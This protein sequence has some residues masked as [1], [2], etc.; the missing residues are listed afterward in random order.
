MLWL[1]F[2]DPRA[3]DAPDSGAGGSASASSSSSA[4]DPDPDPDSETGPETETETDEDSVS[5]GEEVNYMVTLLLPWAITILLHVG[6]ILLAFFL[7]WSTVK[8]V[9]E[10]ETIIPIA[11]LSET[12]GVQLQQRTQTQELTRRTT[13]STSR[14][15]SQSQSQSQSELQSEV[16]TES[17]LIGVAGGA[18]GAKANPFSEA[19]SGS[20]EFKATMYGTGGNAKRIAYLIDASG[21]LIDTLPFVIL[22]LKRSISELKEQQRFTLIF[23]QGE[24]AIEVPPRGLKRADQQTKQKVL[25]W[26]DPKAGNIV[27]AGQSNPVAAIEL[28]LRYKPQLM[29][30]LSDDITGRGRYEVDQHRLIQRV[31]EANKASTKINTIQFLYPDPVASFS[32]AT[33][34]IIA[35]QSGGMYKFLDARELGIQ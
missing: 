9:D 10:E 16:S 26:I 33:L 35:E 14:S 20:T 17:S 6:V 30:I 18:S 8:E 29:F 3:N 23:F 5:V 7:V 1:A 13:R 21:S 28:A 25:R 32:K 27:P 19:I 24:D 12:P 34:E 15:L 22:E 2:A 11:R 4:P 31:A